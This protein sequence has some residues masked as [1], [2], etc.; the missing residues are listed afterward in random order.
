MARAGVQGIARVTITFDDTPTTKSWVT[1]SNLKFGEPPA[2]KSIGAMGGKVDPVTRKYTI[3][4]MNIRFIDDGDLRT[5]LDASRVQGKRI[6]IEFGADTMSATSELQPM[7]KVRFAFFGKHPLTVIDESIGNRIDPALKDSASFGVD[8]QTDISHWTI[9][10]DPLWRAGLLRLAEVYSQMAS[11][12]G[13]QVTSDGGKIR[14]TRA[15]QTSPTA[16]Q[17]WIDGDILE[18]SFRVL[19]TT[20]Q[21]INRI[22]THV[23]DDRNGDYRYEIE[24]NDETAQDDSAYPVVAGADV[25]TLHVF[26]QFTDFDGWEG[27]LFEDLDLTETDFDIES[28]S[29]MPGTIG[30]DDTTGIVPSAQRI[31]ASKPAYFLLRHPETTKVEIVKCVTA[32]ASLDTTDFVDIDFADDLHADILPKELA[33]NIA[34]ELSTDEDKYPLKGVITV[35]RDQFGTSAPTGGWPKGDPD[36][37][38]GFPRTKIHDITPQVIRSLEILN[39][40]ADGAPVITVA[41]HLDKYAVTFG[42][43]V[44]IEQDDIFVSEG[45]PSLTSSVL[46]EVIG[47]RVDVNGGQLIWTLVH[48]RTLPSITPTVGVGFVDI[49]VATSQMLKFLDQQSSWKR[50]TETICVEADDID[51]TRV[52]NITAGSVSGGPNI[53]LRKRSRTG[54]ANLGQLTMLASRDTYIDLDLETRLIYQR[55]VANDTTRSNAPA[56]LSGAI[57]LAR[58]VT[59]GSAV[60]AVQDFRNKG[61]LNDEKVFPTN[62]HKD[63]GLGRGL[64]P[65]AHLELSTRGSGR[66]P[67]DGWRLSGGEW[68]DVAD[69]DTSNARSGLNSVQI[70]AGEATTVIL[71]SPRILVEEG[72]VYVYEAHVKLSTTA[73][74]VSG[75]K[76]YDSSDSLLSTS[77]NVGLTQDVIYESI[78]GSFAAPAS[79][80]YARVFVNKNTTGPSLNVNSL[81]MFKQ[82]TT[83]AISG[84]V[85]GGS[86]TE[87]QFNNVGVLDGDPGLTWNKTNH[88]VFIKGASG[89]TIAPDHFPQ[90]E[91]LVIAHTVNSGESAR[92][93][94]L[95]HAGS[96]TNGIMSGDD[97][98]RNRLQFNMSNVSD[99]FR[100]FI[101]GDMRLEVN[102]TQFGFNEVSP[103]AYWHA[104]EDV[105]ADMEMRW[106]HATATHDVFH[107]VK[108]TTDDFSFGIDESE[109]QFRLSIGATLANTTLAIDTTTGHIGVNTAPVATYQIESRWD[110]ASATSWI[111]AH[112]ATDGTGSA[113]AFR[114]ESN[115]HGGFIGAFAQLH[116]TTAF[117]GNLVFSNFGAGSGSFIFEKQKT[118]EF[119][120]FYSGP[121]ATGNRL[122]RVADQNVIVEETR[123]ANAAFENFVN[124]DVNF[125]NATF[126]NVPRV[127]I[128]GGTT[129]VSNDAIAQWTNN[130]TNVDWFMGNDGG[131]TDRFK[132]WRATLVCMEVDSNRD[133]S[134]GDKDGVCRLGVFDDVD[135]QDG[136]GTASRVNTLNA[137]FVKNTATDGHEVGIGFAHGA[138]VGGTTLPDGV[139]SVERTNATVRKMH[140]KLDDESANGVTTLLTL[141]NDLVVEVPNTVS[142]GVNTPSPSARV[143]IEGDAD[144]GQ[145]LLYL[146]QNDSDQPFIDFDG[147][148]AGNKTA[149]VS[150]LDETNFSD[151]DEWLKVERGTNL[152]WIKLFV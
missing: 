119:F 14:F 35:V 145:E 114:A 129:L 51:V 97:T 10:R 63:F 12:M 90:D 44:S 83:D 53:F 5:E 148:T 70:K 126:T 24:F 102:P 111:R 130:F 150:T 33:G 143:E 20:G 93:V 147:A 72:E 131:D 109:G 23:V 65:N 107:H 2:I 68:T 78:G 32:V 43:I 66:E 4:R 34:N 84:N 58:V 8:A 112:N 30:W 100:F 46:W 151:A 135:H 133:F 21:I 48:M 86:D 39:R 132:L 74:D 138:V 26:D 139:I 64:F 9:G 95:G 121:T 104:T 144:E 122:L 141:R 101:L 37:P 137:C 71:E 92:I 6:D 13:G 28:V 89:A 76:W 61:L 80:R 98:D 127:H 146:D 25:K 94:L 73:Q 75:I 123:S 69:N 60:T 1:G 115:D 62:H 79:A 18:G 120:D 59:N 22:I 125:T 29:G 11:L 124:L 40:F 41:T 113:A 56:E 36:D 42:D 38:S 88:N 118:G 134:L 82:F 15:D 136:T 116:A 7:F 152:R 108:T 67:P 31:G 85:V 110:S 87:I 149:S 96:S 91:L 105:A 19:E 3:S 57:R 106:E 99:H 140:F 52:V 17:D 54:A 103:G 117:A 81:E 128:S 16:D 27:R 47:K 49:G 77:S 50:T 55:D 142:L 45:I